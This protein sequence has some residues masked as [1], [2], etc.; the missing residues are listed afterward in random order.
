MWHEA[1]NDISFT[2]DYIV[3]GEFVQPTTASYR[4]RGHDGTLLD[5]GSLSADSTSEEVV[6]GAAH[7]SISA[8]WEN[9]YY[10]AT[11]VYEGRTYTSDFDYKLHAFVPLM[12]STDQ[13]R[14]LI[15]LDASE[16]PD[17]EI[18]LIEAYYDLADEYSTTFTDAFTATGVSNRKA[19]EAVA[20]KAALAVVHSVPMRTKIQVRTEN[21][22]VVR[23]E[24]IDFEALEEALRRK[25]TSTLG[26]VVP[27]TTPN[28]AL[29]E[30][31]TPTDAITG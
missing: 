21:T 23:S 20:L 17:K 19:N 27:D 1:D 15:G 16:L 9:R 31:S 6:V 24:R 25:L 14:S 3:D 8:D 28:T 29:F 12:A 26:Q 2:V 11:F 10:R 30:L 13:V 7:H 5:S 22:T 18:A 4:L